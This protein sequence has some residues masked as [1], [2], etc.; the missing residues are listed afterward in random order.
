MAIDQIP[1][2][3]IKDDAVTGAKIE[4]NPTIA[5]NLTVSGDLV[6]STPL[7][8]R[9]IIINGG[10]QVWQRGTALATTGNGAYRADRWKNGHDISGTIQ[11]AS[12]TLSTA[13]FNTTG[14][15]T[16]L[17]VSCSA[18]DTSVIAGHQVDSI[19]LKSVNAT[20]NT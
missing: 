15:K 7:S 10:M 2:G 20:H 13:D 4:N 11:N 18:T 12:E 8:H 17:V 6:P 16:A 9:N 19:T 14:H 3:L 5:G 1:T